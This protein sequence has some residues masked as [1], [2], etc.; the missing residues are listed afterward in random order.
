MPQE[1]ARDYQ[2]CTK[3]V[4]DTSD[5]NITFDHEG[6]CC[7]YHDFFKNVKPHWNTGPEGRRRLEAVVESIK[8]AGRKRD[9]D[10]LMGL[11][12]VLTAPTCCT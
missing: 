2:I 12:V 4:M 8:E 7:Y 1:D 11:V 6:I 3:L 9:F 10:C 5:P